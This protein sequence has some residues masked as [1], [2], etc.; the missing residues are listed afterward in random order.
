MTDAT[1]KT[2]DWSAQTGAGPILYQSFLVPAMFTPFAERLIDELGVAEGARVLD[3]ACGTGAV[4]RV[5]ARAA[6]AAGSVTGVDLG[7][8]MLAVAREQP[9]DEGAAPITY[10]EGRAEELPVDDAA[11]DRVTC[12]HG[13]QFF[14][15]R[16]A[17]LREM[18]RALVPG[19]RAAVAVWGAPAQ[20]PHFAALADVLERHLPEGAEIMRSPFAISAPDKLRAMLEAAGFTDVDVEAHT[21]PVVY[22]SADEFGPRTLGAGPLAPMF[23]AAPADVQE[24]IG[25]DV[26]QALKPWATEDGRLATEMTS[27]VAFGSA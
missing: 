21:L 19:G 17:A 4:S 8:P 5:A 2:M 9:A 10:L 25:R 24:A 16:D 11:F 1:P 26:A 18:R 27:I 14:T 13:L 12:H 7:A 20:Q 6:G 3:V 15:D 22:E 23:N